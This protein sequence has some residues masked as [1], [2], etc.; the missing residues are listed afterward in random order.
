MKCDDSH[1][2]LPDQADLPPVKKSNFTINCAF[3]MLEKLEHPDYKIDRKGIEQCFQFSQ[4]TVLNEITNIKR[5]QQINFVEFLDMLCRV[6]IVGL[7]IEDTLDYK[8]HILLQL[9]YKKYYES[10][11]LCREAFPLYPVDEKLR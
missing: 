6:A 11:E 8:T 5:Y 9:I 2:N 7:D 10:D 3:R 4:M 1:P